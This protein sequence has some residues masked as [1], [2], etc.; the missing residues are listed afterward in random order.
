MH[1]WLTAWNRFSAIYCMKYPDQQAQLAKHLEAVREIADAKGNWKDYDRDFRT[2]VAQGQVAWGD[3]HMELYV[4]ARLTTSA[5][6]QYHSGKHCQAGMS[7]RFQHRCYNCSGAHPFVQCTKP[8]KHPFRV[9]QKYQN[10]TSNTNKHSTQTKTNS[11]SKQGSYS[12]QG[13]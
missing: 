5:C 6:F 8:T 3:V 12:N 1:D 11:S 2:L 9:M 7:C 10:Q 4:N 13:K